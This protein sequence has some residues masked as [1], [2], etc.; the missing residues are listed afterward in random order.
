MQE[1]VKEQRKKIAVGD[2]G[3]I[4]TGKRWLTILLRELIWLGAAYLLGRATLLF[5]T[6]PLGLALLCAARGQVVSILLGLLCAALTD[7]QMPVM[8]V[9]VYLAVGLIRLAVQ[10]LWD[11]S[12]GQVELPEALQKKLG[13]ERKD[14]EDVEPAPAGEDR[15][16]PASLWEGICLLGKEIRLA[17][18]PSLRL[19]ICLGEVA[20][21]LLCLYRIIAGGFL[22]YD[23]F[24]A[25]FS[26]AVTP[27]AILVYS[28]VQDPQRHWLL[29]RAALL[30]L[31]ASLIWAA[32]ETELWG[33]SLA[34]ILGVLFTFLLCHRYGT[35]T[36]ALGGILMGAVYQVLYAPSFLLAA[37]LCGLSK[38]KDYAGAGMVT[39]IFSMLAWAVYVGG[40][41]AVWTFLPTGLLA[42]MIFSLVRRMETREK[43]SA[44]AAENTPKP[45][46]SNQRHQDANE[47]FRGISEA[48]SSLSEVFYNLSDRFRR[49]GTL[50]LRRICDASFDAYCCDCPNKSICWGLEYSATLNTVNLLISRLHT[51]GRV[52]REQMSEALLRRCEAAEQILEKINRDCARLTGE[53]LDNNRTEIFAMDYEATAKIINDALEEDDGE[54]RF[55]EEAERRIGEYLRDAGIG[56]GSVTVY[57]NRRRRILLRDVCIDQAKVTVETLRSDLGEMCGL[58]LGRPTF[59]VENNVSTMTLQARRRISVLGARNNVSAD[60]GISGDTVNLFSNKK[61]YFYALISDGMGSGT[62]AAF[63][64][65]LCSVF[66]EK[67]LRAGNR[68]GT[69]LRMLNNLICSRE[70]GSVRECSSTVDLLELD[71]VTAQATFFKG[72]AAPS[73]IIRGGAVHRL[74][75]G[76]APIGILPGVEMRETTF[77]L[78]P[79]DTVVMVSDGILQEAGE[80]D[81]WLPT[82]LADAGEQTPEELVY[83]ICLHASEVEGHDD[84]S[85]V[86]LRILEERAG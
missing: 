56:T 23:L 39:A 49:P 5:E 50:D 18:H 62:E 51:R 69:S 11:P 9:C 24:A 15:P 14:G 47:R 80:E 16:M 61:D 77:L 76:T 84:C 55:D 63:T 75:M 17:L 68:A 10:W 29:Q 12:Q 79:G 4:W 45:P 8:Y 85:A 25:L 64:S 22:Y 46:V 44:D 30:L 53:M 82:F 70:V 34:V 78:Q 57:G 20:V 86:A 36:G 83:R 48:F 32:R 58:S 66:L 37:L 60:G 35:V 72:G 54:Y 52:E 1:Q 42:G 33:I 67:M 41:G 65:N 7:L 27:L 59:E 26:L 31:A 81:A 73:F 21:L 28:L 43:P 19:R 71:L 2:R 13:I 40:F 3:G 6:Q 74:Q 38:R